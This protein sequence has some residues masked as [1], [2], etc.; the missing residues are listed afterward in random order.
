MPSGL[1]VKLP[2]GAVPCGRL[3]NSAKAR[4]AP[5]RGYRAG[6]TKPVW[7]KPDGFVVWGGSDDMPHET[8]ERGFTPAIL[9]ADRESVIEHGALHKPLHLS[10]AYGYREVAG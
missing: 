10:V 8:R 6:H 4:F 1:G 2:T 5:A 3:K 7:R 9:H